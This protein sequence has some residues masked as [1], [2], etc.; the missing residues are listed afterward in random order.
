MNNEKENLR[1]HS[2]RDT[3]KLSLFLFL[4]LI[5]FEVAFCFLNKVFIFF[6]L[7][8][9]LLFVYVIK[10]YI[11]FKNAQ[12]CYGKIID[13][14]LDDYK[15]DVYLYTKIAFK[16][17]DSNKV[18]ETWIYEHWGDFDEESKKAIS[19]FYKKGKEKIG[20]RVPVF[21]NKKNPNKNLVFVDNE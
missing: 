13:V 8:F 20:K 19:E 17:S 12:F 16:D 10:W 7:L 4:I 21:Y 15:D 2:M 11:F 6:I 18:Y 1:K 3:I 9:I 5:C 14:T